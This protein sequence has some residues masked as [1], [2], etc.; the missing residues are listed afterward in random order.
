MKICI[1][2]IDD[3]TQPSA[4]VLATPITKGKKERAGRT[5]T[6]LEVMSAITLMD[7]VDE[8]SVLKYCWGVWVRHPRKIVRS[9]TVYLG[10]K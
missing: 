2:C 3:T 6:Y 9:S 7:A 10:S 5:N 4:A 1:G 8:L